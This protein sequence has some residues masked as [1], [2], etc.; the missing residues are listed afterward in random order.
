MW[1]EDSV[2]SFFF[3]ERRFH[4]SFGQITTMSGWEKG[5]IAHIGNFKGS[6]NTMRDVIVLPT[7]PWYQVPITLLDTTTFTCLFV[8]Q[9]LRKTILT[10]N[11][12]RLC[13]FVCSLV[14][15]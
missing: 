9:L 8:S 2:F 14:A 5:L 13:V 6:L 11:I 1:A 7:S 15:V 12:R 3:I 4:Q 10:L